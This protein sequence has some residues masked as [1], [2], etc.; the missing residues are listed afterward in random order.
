MHN[1]TNKYGGLIQVDKFH[2][3]HVKNLYTCTI[4]YHTKEAHVS[5]V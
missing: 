5:C 1:N 3:I 4:Q 2:N